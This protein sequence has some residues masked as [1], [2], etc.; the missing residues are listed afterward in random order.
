MRHLLSTEKKGILIPQE[1]SVFP[2]TFN[3]LPGFGSPHLQTILACFTPGGPPPP[4]ITKIFTLEDGDALCCEV[5]TPPKW[6]ETDKTII[7]LHGLGGCHTASYMVRLSRKLYFKGY[8]AIRVNMRNCGSGRTFA[9]MPYHGGLSS[10][11]FQVVCA[12]KAESPLS[13]I[14]TIGYSLGGNIALKLAGE[15]GEKNSDLVHATIAVC[16]PINLAETAEIMA[17]PINN[18]YNRYYM[19]HL[20]KLTKQW[21]EGR[22]F[23]SIYEFD[24]LVTAPKWGFKSPAEYY[25][26]SS[27]CY[28]LGLIQHPCHILLAED[29]PF[30]N[31]NTCLGA[32]RSDSTKIWVSKYGGHMGFFGWADKEYGY[33]WLDRLL[34]N[35]ISEKF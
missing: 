34:L 19:Y 32:Q 1:N 22:P 13:P 27:S 31:H 17:L 5:S 6:K 8:R 25:K 2:L 14:I 26:S 30:I 16:P 28:K 24:E 21:T 18:L 11:I 4:S 35:W 12:L 29:D 3:P 23:S 9:K 33:Y 20:D 15:L 10:D 7:L